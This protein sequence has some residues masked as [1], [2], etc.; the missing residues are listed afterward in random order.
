MT[1]NIDLTDAIVQIMILKMR[2]GEGYAVI[3]T[4]C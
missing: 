4:G 2:I 3:Y 1:K